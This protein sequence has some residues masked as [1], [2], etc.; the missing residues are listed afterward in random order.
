MA[1][2]LY[3]LSDS[4]RVK[5]L[6]NGAHGS[7]QEILLALIFDRL[8]LLCYSQTKDAS[9]GINQPKSVAQILMGRLGDG[10]EKNE[11]IAYASGE[12]FLQA[13]NKI[14]KGEVI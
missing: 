8:N 9:L 7:L 2:F 13:R 5:K 11:I 14:L 12:E 10:D 4:S 6:Y 1:I 3:G